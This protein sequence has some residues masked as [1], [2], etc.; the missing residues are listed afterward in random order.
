M[1]FIHKQGKRLEA[2]TVAEEAKHGHGILY[3]EIIKSENRFKVAHVP[4]ASIPDEELKKRISENKYLFDKIF[5]VLL[6]EDDV[7]MRVIRI[8]RAYSGDQSSRKI[9]ESIIEEPEKKTPLKKITPQSQSSS[10]Q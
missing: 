5:F 4:L 3:V 10:S 1:D 7:A 6:K 8:N 2:V 9:L